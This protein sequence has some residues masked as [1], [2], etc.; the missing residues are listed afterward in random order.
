[1]C[2]RLLAPDMAASHPRRHFQTSA[3]ALG[4]RLLAA[5]RSCAI[6]GTRSASLNR[7]FAAPITPLNL[8][9]RFDLE[10]PGT[11]P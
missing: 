5:F 4:A 11:S 1:M 10:P 6:S 8:C 7:K 3:P 9:S 2:P